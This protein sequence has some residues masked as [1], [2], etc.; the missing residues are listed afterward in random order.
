MHHP[1]KRQNMHRRLTW[2][3]QAKTTLWFPLAVIALVLALLE[4][5]FAQSASNPSGLPLPRFAT[6][7]S[8]PINV[9]VGP[10]TR[11]E[12]TWVYV[13]AG[14]PIEII[15]EF[16]TW[17]KIRDFEGEEGWIHQNL[18]SGRRAGHVNT[19]GA[20]GQIAL[21]AKP[22]QQADVRAWLGEK[23]PVEIEKCDGN[24]CAVRVKA[25]PENAGSKAYAG[26]LPQSSLWGVYA[27]E[28]FK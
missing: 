5:A 19:T 23:Y 11:Y 20:S 1:A 17:R 4:P 9:R 7:R 15:Q 28:T 12:V 27:Q 10:G 26:F 22:D 13:K 8:Q 18:L 6:T 14:I 21:R 24:W 16:D 3:H 25:E 2:P